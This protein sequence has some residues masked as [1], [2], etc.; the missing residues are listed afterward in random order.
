M[1]Q[2][3]N[4][5]GSISSRLLRLVFSCYFFLTLGVTIVQMTLEYERTKD[6]FVLDLM[7]QSE[8]FVPGLANALWNYDDVA[9]EQTIMGLLKNKNIDRVSIL[10]ESGEIFYESERKQEQKE[11][12]NQKGSE[13]LEWESMQLEFDIYINEGENTKTIGGGILHTSEK[14]VFD[15]VKYGFVLIFL[16]SIIKTLGLWFL[17]I[18]FANKI[19]ARPLKVISN[20]IS[21]YKVNGLES[22]NDVKNI[23]DTK[24]NMYD[25]LKLVSSTFTKMAEEIAEDTII[26][27]EYSNT[28]EKKVKNR[29]KQ[30]EQKS[31]DLGKMLQSMKLGVFTILPDHS[32]DKEYSQHL[33]A[34]L[35][36]KYISG[37]N[38]ISLLTDNS[39]L[40]EDHINQIRSAITTII[41]SHDFVFKVNAHIFPSEI[42]LKLREEK[43]YLELEWEPI[44]DKES[45]EIEKIMVIVRDVTE[46]RNL[47]RVSET[48]NTEIRIIEEILNENFYTFSSFI[49]SLKL[50]KNEAWN[51]VNK[52]EIDI[53]SAFR[54]IHTIKGNSRLL[55]YSFISNS[56]HNLENYLAKVRSKEIK[57]DKTNLNGEFS[58]LNHIVELYT[59]VYND[60]MKVI[61]SNSDSTIVKECLSVIKKHNLDLDKSRISCLKNLRALLNDYSKVTFEDLINMQNKGL[62]PLC[63]ELGKRQPFILF[64]GDNFLID[65]NQKI[66]I[67]DIMTHLFRNSISHG[68]ES[69]EDRVAKGKPREG[70]ISIE[71]K[72]F[73][74]YYSIKYSDDGRGLDLQSLRQKG[75]KTG[76]ISETSSDKDIA[77]TIFKPGVSTT[78]KLND[79]SG[80]G[81][82]LDAVKNFLEQS[83]GA[84]TLEFSGIADENL[85]QS[86][87]FMVQIPKV[88]KT[89]LKDV[90]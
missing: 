47:R 23:M 43:K 56:A 52:K 67:V 68:L 42:I 73:D 69:D 26:I 11:A 57:L 37:F 62:V 83:G 60:R 5:R 34:I 8:N 14:I 9:L 87:Y 51:C 20:A 3:F 85:F 30:L 44:V 6:Q 59:N 41:H 16:N 76:L 74:D 2:F 89:S 28:L 18:F 77:Y 25:E 38:G 7:S 13:I 66:A 17:F 32:V 53:E 86:F 31:A 10:D 84:I 1:P 29:T 65:N 55:G 36:R 64:K 90:S 78:E 79:I 81:V 45:E 75:K 71:A 22:I 63:K 82:G 33:E 40:S 24:E 35:Q 39:N 50:M 72:E 27:K 80:R 61:T 46:V 88:A 70:M 12:S 21:K 15:R 54:L 58:E 49:K 48:Q 19:V 4:G